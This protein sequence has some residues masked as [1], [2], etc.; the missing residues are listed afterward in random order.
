MDYG[1]EYTE[2]QRRILYRRLRRQY[3][4]AQKNV[5]QK[6]KDFLAGSAAREKLYEKKVE[7]GL[8]TQSWFDNWK[9]GQ[10]FIGKRWNAKLDEVTGTLTEANQKA[11]AMIRGEQYKV[12]AE[13][14]NYQSYML[15]KDGQKHNAGISF[16]IYDET[17]VRRLIQEKPELMKRS[18]WKSRK[19]K[20]WNQGIISNSIAQGIIQ[21]ESIPKIA[22]RIAR[23]TCDRNNTHMMLYARTAMTCAQNS[24]RIET[25]HRAT[26][27]G[28]HVKKEWIA[29]LDSR[30]RDSH[31]H[32]D[33]QT[34]EVDEPFSSILGDIMFPGDPDAE[35][36]N[37]WNCRCSLGSVYVDFES[38]GNGKRR[39]QETGEEIED[40]TYDEWK[41][42]KEEQ[43]QPEPLKIPEP[44]KEEEPEKQ[45]E[46][47]DLEKLR[48]IAEM[49][50][51][52]VDFWMNLDEEQQAIFKASGLTIDEAF[53]Q[54]GGGTGEKSEWK[55][56]NPG[57]ADSFAIIH[58]FSA[59]QIEFVKVEPKGE[60]WMADA[61]DAGI[62]KIR[63]DGL[64]K[65]WEFIIY[66][67]AGHQLSD[68]CQE[69][70]EMILYNPGNVL[71]RFNNRLM[72]F[73][74]IYGEYSPEEAF[75]TGVSVFMRHPEAMKEKYPEAYNA[76]GALFEASPSA[77]E[78]V[79]RIVKEYRRMFGI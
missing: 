64:G 6:L 71:G 31:Q 34:A 79:E 22:E 48:A 29:T 40:M 60:G 16:D 57:G 11:L 68:N 65:D 47:N 52:K 33:G 73:D 42:W 69:L 56:A 5:E 38:D 4:E 44:P 27:M 54:L 41:E 50:T 1:A 45:D 21:G 18:T 28:L 19:D 74:G 77:K 70:A 13:N 78:Y 53:E 66:H 51:D 63:K 25:M 62:I 43:N 24:G 46:K 30:T 15:E 59:S 35:P 10:V 37:V 2:R 75:A 61:D 32:L 26:D 14:S 72:A 67:E 12:F 76:I 23:D 9:Q 17:T 20:A 55:E 58:D 7:A 36:A 49:S 3:R 8:L 39:D